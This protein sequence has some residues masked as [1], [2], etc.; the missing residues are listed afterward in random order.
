MDHIYSNVIWTP[1][2]SSQGFDLGVCITSSMVVGINIWHSFFLCS[3]TFP[4]IGEIS[5]LCSFKQ[6][7]TLYQPSVAASARIYFVQHSPPSRRIDNTLQFI[8][9]Y[10][11]LTMNTETKLLFL[12]I[13]GEWKIPAILFLLNGI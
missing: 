3:R 11:W 9:L 13:S 8:P 7:L 12:S 1:L 10:D 6:G 4:C 5:V 2:R